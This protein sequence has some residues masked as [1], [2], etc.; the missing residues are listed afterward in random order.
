[1]IYSKFKTYK[2]NDAPSKFKTPVQNKRSSMIHYT[3][4]DAPKKVSYEKKGREDI[5]YGLKT[6]VQNKRSEFDC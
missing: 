4:N 2:K 6:P 3:K 1:M 5:Q